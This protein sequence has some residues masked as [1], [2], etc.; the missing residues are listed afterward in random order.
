[1]RITLSCSL[2]LA[3]PHLHQPGCRVCFPESRCWNGSMTALPTLTII[4][5][6]L[7]PT[8]GIDDYDGESTSSEH[9]PPH[10]K[11]GGTRSAMLTTSGLPHPHH[12]QPRLYLLCFPDRACSPECYSL[13]RAETVLLMGKLCQ[14]MTFMR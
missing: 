10:G 9:M 2:G 13:R 4:G 8:S 11:G 7:P 12:C 3:H 1:M 6:T 5:P 14:P